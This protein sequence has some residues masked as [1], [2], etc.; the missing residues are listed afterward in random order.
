MKP[1]IF[2]GC[3]VGIVALQAPLS[4]AAVVQT[5]GLISVTGALDG[6]LIAPGRVGDTLDYLKFE[7]PSSGNVTLTSGFGS[8]LRLLLAQFIGVQNEFGFVGNPYWLQQTSEEPASFTRPLAAGTYV[9]A[10]GVKDHTS[11][12]I[13]DGFV[14][15]NREGGGFTFTNYA[16]TVE[17]DVQALE[18]WDGNLDGTFTVT[19]IPE[20]GAVSVILFIGAAGILRRRRILR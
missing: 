12:D 7:M 2:V 5:P 3:A 18:Y 17:G 13:F 14:A 1:G 19:Q 15:V 10:M 16:Y 9:L 20:P 8:G 6:G 11:Y 4:Q